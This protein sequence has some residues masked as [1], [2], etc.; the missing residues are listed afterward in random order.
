MVRKRR[1]SQWRLD[2]E[3]SWDVTWKAFKTLEIVFKEWRAI[4]G[5][6]EKYGE[7]AV[8]RRQISLHSNDCNRLHTCTYHAKCKTREMDSLD[9]YQ[10]LEC[11]AAFK[12]TSRATT[13]LVY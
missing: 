3:L 9:L 7:G 12:T 4:I 8:K 2:A 11:I 6:C 5:E 13:F 10:P 1:D